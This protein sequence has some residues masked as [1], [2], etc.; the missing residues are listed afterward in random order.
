[1]PFVYSTLANDNILVKYSIP[2]D[3]NKIPVETARILIKGGAGVSTGKAFITPR[4]VVT[5]VTDEQLDILKSISDFQDHVKTG[6]MSFTDKEYSVES[7]VPDMIARDNSAPLI[8]QDF[9]ESDEDAPQPVV[10][11]PK[12]GKKS[13]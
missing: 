4:G 2:E 5:Q 7:I 10:G 11:S 8:P 13:A 3:K 12:K 9:D 6:Y 1:M